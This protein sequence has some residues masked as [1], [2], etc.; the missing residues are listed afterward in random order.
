MLVV[1]R[2]V[3]ALILLRLLLAVSRAS[4]IRRIQARRVS[5][6]RQIQVRQVILPPVLQL[7]L[8]LVPYLVQTRFH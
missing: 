6:I 3:F 8:Q 2:Y 1:L 7:A 5:S 4:S